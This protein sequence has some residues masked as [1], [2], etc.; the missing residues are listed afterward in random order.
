MRTFVSCFLAC[1]LLIALG[2]FAQDTT[3]KPPT[4][5]VFTTKNGNVTFDHAAHL[6]RA[7]NDCKTCHETLFKQ[8]SKAPLNYKAMLHK[9]AEADKT[10]CA[11]CHHA[12]G[13][14]FESKGN[15]A[16][17]HVKG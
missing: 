11:F 1:G 6:M 2:V 4:K 8:D 9:T 12:G 3:K 17:C 14:S 13:A 5:L 10:S 16:K 7:K 15:C